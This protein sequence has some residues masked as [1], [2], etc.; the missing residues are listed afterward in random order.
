MFATP[1]SSRPKVVPFP[2]LTLT[3]YGQNIG[4]SYFPDADGLIHQA[5]K[6]AARGVI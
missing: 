3:P 4:T 6:N 2:F 1:F 5:I